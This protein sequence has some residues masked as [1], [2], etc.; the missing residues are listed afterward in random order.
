MGRPALCNG[1]RQYTLLAALLAALHPLAALLAQ[2]E[3]GN[4]AS[5]L[6]LPVAM[7]RGRTGAGA[8]LVRKEGRSKWR[9]V[10]K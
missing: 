3:A 7:A 2:Q 5:V 1:R 9:P 4:D 8:Q 10:S 6:G